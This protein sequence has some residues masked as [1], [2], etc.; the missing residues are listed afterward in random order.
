MIY[1]SNEELN[2]WALSLYFFHSQKI[3]I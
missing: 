3:T 2:F 1:I